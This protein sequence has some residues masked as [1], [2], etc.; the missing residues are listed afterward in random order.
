MSPSASS[1]VAESVFFLA[2]QPSSAWTFELDLRPFG[3]RW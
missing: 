3:E 1:S 2:R